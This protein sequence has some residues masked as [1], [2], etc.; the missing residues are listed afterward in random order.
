MERLKILFLC[1]GNSARSQIAEALAT[2]MAKNFFECFSAGSR[3]SDKVHPLAVEVMKEAGIDISCAKTK[4]W[5]EYSKIRFN[6]VI[7][8][9]EEDF[10]K[11]PVYLEDAVKLRWSLP[12]PVDFQD[13]DRLAK[14]VFTETFLNIRNRLNHFIALNERHGWKDKD[15]VEK[16]NQ[17]EKYHDE[18]LV[19]EICRLYKENVNIVDATKSKMICIHESELRLIIRD[20]IADEKSHDIATPGSVFLAL[21]L[22]FIS[23]DFSDFILSK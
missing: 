13:D 20:E 11:C 4:S 19:K 23:S 17:L 15:A 18:A 1:V 7:S 22:C 6:Y 16:Q 2:N 5:N 8:L 14:K 3:P 12:D 21:L 9:C 10:E